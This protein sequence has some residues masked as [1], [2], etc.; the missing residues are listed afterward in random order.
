[1]ERKKW[2]KTDRIGFENIDNH[3]TELEP[4]IFDVLLG[5]GKGDWSHPGNVYLL[6]TVYICC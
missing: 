5:Q 2:S 3:T 4:E 1:M 6:G